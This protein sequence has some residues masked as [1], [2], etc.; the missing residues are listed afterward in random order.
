MESP[1]DSQK[2]MCVCVCVC[3]HTIYINKNL[4]L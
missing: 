2:Q 4:H 1:Q 3:G